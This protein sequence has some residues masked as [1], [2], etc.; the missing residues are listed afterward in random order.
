MP[1]MRKLDL[2]GLKPLPGHREQRVKL[3]ATEPATVQVRR[4]IDGR[5]S[6][7][8]RDVYTVGIAQLSALRQRL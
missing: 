3:T 2:A 5:R 1:I 4:Q 7:H 8:E 6:A